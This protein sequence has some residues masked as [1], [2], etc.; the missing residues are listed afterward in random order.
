MNTNKY[1]NKLDEYK[2]CC[3]YIKQIHS[4][5]AYKYHLYNNCITRSTIVI[6]I[7]L[8]AV[9]FADKNFLIT[10]LP[11]STNNDINNIQNIEFI[12]NLLVLITLILTILNLICRFQE[13]SI[14]Y[15]NSV[16]SLSTFIQKIEDFKLTYLDDSAIKD[17]KITDREF[18]QAVNCY[19]KLQ[20]VFVNN[21]EVKDAITHLSGAISSVGIHAGGVV[22]A[23]KQI[24]NH[25]PLM[26][27]S[28]T[29]VLPVCQ[30]NMDGIHYLRGL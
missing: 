6:T 18:T 29:A 25:I 12:L 11:F 19:N 5:K 20:E 17:D 4:N 28:E 21:P 8:S 30:T 22:I 26:K 14:E 2:K 23:G 1:E 9:A 13:K 10:I 16:K 7:V 15:F 3:E 27:G 24:Q